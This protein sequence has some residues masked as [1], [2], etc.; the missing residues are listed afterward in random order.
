V[1]AVPGCDSRPLRASTRHHKIFSNL[2]GIHQRKSHRRV[3][4][5]QIDR[6]IEEARI[7][8]LV[9]QKWGRCSSIAGALS[10]IESVLKNL[11]AGFVGA[12]VDGID[13]TAEKRASGLRYRSS[14]TR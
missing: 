2:T 7:A 3:H 12:H 14:A 8:V 11:I 10:A 13:G 9:N 6:P 1:T 5:R 4:K